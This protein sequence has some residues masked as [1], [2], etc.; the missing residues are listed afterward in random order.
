MTYST[1]HV[2]VWRASRSCGRRRDGGE[3]RGGGVPLFGDFHTTD[4]QS[5]LVSVHTIVIFAR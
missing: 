1:Q 3:S 5:I 2:D 4:S